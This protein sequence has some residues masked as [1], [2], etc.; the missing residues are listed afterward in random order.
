MK[1]QAILIAA[2]AALCMIGATQRTL[3][4]LT[5]SITVTNH[6]DTSIF[7]DIYKSTYDQKG[8]I[9]PGESFKDNVIV[10]I[11]TVSI[12]FYE[13]GH[14]GCSGPRVLTH[15]IYPHH[16]RSA[17]FEAVGKNRDYRVVGR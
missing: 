1:K 13:P 2:F 10:K 6:S 8:C 5:Y 7:Y 4:D 16:R 17:V 3:A 9:A 14:H 11:I 12:A 15:V